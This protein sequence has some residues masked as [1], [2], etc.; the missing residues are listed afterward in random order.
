MMMET[1]TIADRLAGDLTAYFANNLVTEHRRDAAI[2]HT[3]FVMP[4][5]TCISIG[6]S[7]TADGRVQLSDLAIVSNFF[8]TEGRSLEDEPSLQ[9]SAKTI[10]ARFGVQITAPEIMLCTEEPRVGMDAL[11]FA[12]ALMSIASLY[13]RRHRRAR[14]DFT[15]RMKARLAERLPAGIPFHPDHTITVPLPEYQNTVSYS[16]DAAVLYEHPKFVQAVGGASSAWRVATVY[17]ALRQ[18]NVDYSGAIVY[19]EEGKSWTDRYRTVLED[20][21]AGLVVPA[22]REDEV[23]DWLGTEDVA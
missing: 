15:T 2:V 12:Q 22:S 21:P 16:V 20:T 8:F 1:T 19:D 18:H 13:D 3:P 9:A 6:V 5:D 23:F 14:P 10:A 11:T 4:D 7:E 17:H